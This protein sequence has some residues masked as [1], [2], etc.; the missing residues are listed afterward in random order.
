MQI[1]QKGFTLV[2]LVI[3]MVVFIVI[4]IIASNSFN[5]IIG[6][7][8]KL[9]TSEESNIEG[10]V[11]LE[12]FRHDLEQSGFGLPSAFQASPPQYTEASVAPANS[13]NESADSVPR[14]VFAANDVTATGVL[15]KTD[16]LVIKGTTLGLSQTSQRWTYVNYSS[17]GNA[18]KT[19]SSG[20]LSTGDK[21]IVLRRVFSDSGVSNQL[22]YQTP[23]KFYATIPA[24]NTLLDADF[25]PLPHETLTIYGVDNGTSLSMPFNRADYFV[26][27]PTQFGQQLPARCAPNTGV[28]F[29]TVV[30][31]SGG[32][33][34][35]VPILDCVADMQVVFGWD[36]N[37][38]GLID[39]YTNADGSSCS[40]TTCGQVATLIT[41]PDGIRNSLKLIKVYILAQDGARDKNFTNSSTTILVGS[42]E[43]G[44][45]TLTKNYDLS[46]HNLMNYHWKVY[47]IIVN[48]KNL[49]TQ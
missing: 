2:E 28:L 8:T 7:N 4:I 14:P 33:L 23:T 19:W 35:P 27:D 16:Y 32:T 15:A 48:P 17:S 47:R 25:Q 18:P 13:Y 3:V 36:A 26:G 45:I 43:N 40:G 34:T 42:Q 49:S 30:N 10:I 31:Q 21:A 11:G 20:N 5:T 6:Q 1:N 9:M 38:D 24:P 12:M 44:E 29:K 37:G 46:G 41:T 22:V 39:A